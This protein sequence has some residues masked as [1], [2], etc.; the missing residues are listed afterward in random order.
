MKKGDP[1]YL[2]D[3]VFDDLYRQWE[4]TE[5]K[6]ERNASGGTQGNAE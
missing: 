1:V 4:D 3:K 5:K 2:D 6:Q